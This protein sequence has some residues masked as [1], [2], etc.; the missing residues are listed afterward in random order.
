MA[1]IGTLIDF[2]DGNVLY[3][4][5]LDSNFGDIRTVVN[6]AVVHTDKASQTITK[7]IT[8]TPDSGQGFVVS[9]GGATIT[10]GGLTVTAGGLTVT[11]GGVTVAAGTTAVQALTCTTLAPSGTSTLQAVT[12]TT[13]SS[14]G[15][16]TGT[17]QTAAQTNITSVG[18]LSALTISGT[19][20]L[21]NASPLSLAATSK[22]VVGA[23]AF[24]IKDSGDSVTA[25]GMTGTGTSTAV[26]MGCGSSG[27]I[28]ITGPGSANFTL[29]NSH[30]RVNATGGNIY[31][32]TDGA[33]PKASTATTNFPCIPF[34]NATPNGILSTSTQIGA[35]ALDESNGCLAVWTSTGW[36]KIVHASY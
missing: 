4:A 3:A 34:F 8:F 15:G 12:C 30:A 17:L 21:S 7:T 29:S 9:T 11:A 14:S 36:R 33:N 25:L 32:G 23:S 10:A 22:F 20:T 27:T 18:T 31:L 24:S 5:Q 35:L 28:V 1:N 26:T 2:T 6:N 16:I 13:L 19:L